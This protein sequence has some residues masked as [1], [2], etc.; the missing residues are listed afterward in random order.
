MNNNFFQRQH[1]ANEKAL[2][3]ADLLQIFNLQDETTTEQ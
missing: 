1:V 2:K 3:L